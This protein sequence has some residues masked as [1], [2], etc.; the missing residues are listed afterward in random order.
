MIL[1]VYPKNKENHAFGYIITSHYQTDPYSLL[2]FMP[3][4]ETL[5]KY[6]FVVVTDN[7]SVK[8]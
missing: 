2:F 7:P 1:R 6:T 5:L 3:S 4:Q 8:S